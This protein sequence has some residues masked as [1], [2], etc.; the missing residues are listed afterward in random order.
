[1]IA[2]RPIREPARALF[3][4]ADLGGNVHPIRA[5]AEA[6]SRRGVV[7][8]LAGVEA[9]GPDLSSVPFG[10]AAAISAD[11]RR[12]WREFSALRRLMMGRGTSEAVR[13]LV[14]ERCA[15][16]V[17]VDCMIPAV[18]RGALDSGVP[19]VALFHT[20]GGYWARPFDRGLLGML[21]GAFGLRPSKLWA[22]AA[23]R[24]LLTDPELD[25][26][27][28]LPEL[29]HCIWTGTTE[30]GAEP[31]PRS[32][33]PRVLVALSSSDWPGM[34]PV[35]RRIIDA[36]V[37]VDADAVVTTGGVD[38]GGHLIGRA[39]VE[40]CGWAPHAE[41]LPGV[42]LLIGHGGHSTTMKALAHGVPLLILPVNTTADQRCI[43]TAIERAGLGRLLSKRAS[44]PAI[45]RTVE[46]MLADEALHARATD[47]ARRLRDMPRGA[48][49]AADHIWAVGDDACRGDRVSG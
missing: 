6:L 45:R 24:L 30:L 44:A 2:E 22:A 37:Q 42:D 25:P 3:F 4:T 28:S 13:A 43:G 9:S 47:T 23:A 5:V 38:L 8:E 18:L 21:F 32:G 48:E 15:D 33:R 40:V 46:A 31:E 19:V 29:A 14:A 41:L 34:L 39:N 49:T 17:A 35:Y 26:G 16:V 11:G 12:G 7:V 1:M 36:L 27:R 20:F 10:P